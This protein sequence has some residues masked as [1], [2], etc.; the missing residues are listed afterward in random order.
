MLFLG[1]FRFMKKHLL[2]LL[3]LFLSLQ[4]FAQEPLPHYATEEEKSIFKDY[5][6]Q[7]SQQRDVAEP[8]PFEVRTMAEWEE[9]Q[10][11]VIT[12]TGFTGILTEI[13]RAAVEECTVL[14]VTNNPANTQ[15]QLEAANVPLDNIEF[16]QE[17]FNSIWI[18]DYGPWTVYGNDVD[19]LVL[20]DW[21][22]NRPRPLD[23]EIPLA[24]ANHLNLDIYEATSEPYNWVHTGGNHLRDGMGTAFS[25]DLV[26]DE[27]PGKTEE[28]IDNIAAEFLGVNRYIKLP[29]LPYDGISHLDMHM[30]IIDEET[31]IIGEYPEGVA[32]GPQIEEN[33]QYIK[34]NFQTPFGNEYN[35]VRI[36]MPPDQFDRY[37]DENGFYRTFTNSLFINKTIIVPIYEEQYDTTALR[38]Y[39]EN[40]P[41]YNVVGIDCNDIIPSLGALHCITKLVGANDPLWI[42]H[43]RIRDTYNTT[44]THL[45]KAIIKHKSGIENATL[46]YRQA[47][48]PAYTAVDMVLVDA[49]EDLWEASIPAQSAGTEIHYYIHATANSGKE[50]VR[51]LVAPEGYFKFEVLEVTTYPT[52]QFF[53]TST[54]ACPDSPI[55]FKDDSEGFVESWAWEFE[56]GTPA[57]STEQNPVVTF[58]E[59]GTYTVTLITTNSIGATSSTLEEY[60]TILDDGIIPDYEGFDDFSADIWTIENPTNDGAEWTIGDTQLCYDQAI[61]LDNFNTD[62][63]G[64]SDFINSRINLTNLGPVELSFDVAYAPYND[65]FFDGLRISV[66]DCDGVTTVVYDK[67][68]AELATAA[69]TTDAFVPS[70]EDWRHEVV[71]LSDFSG[72]VNIQIENRG[73]Y[74]N[75]L[76]LDNV[77]FASPVLANAAPNVAITAPADGTTYLNDLP[78]IT[79]DIDANDSDGNVQMVELFVNGESIGTTNE[80]PYSFGYTIPELG[81]YELVAIATDNLGEASTS[82][83]VTVI[84]D[85]ETNATEIFRELGIEVLPNPV[86]DILKLRLSAN[87]NNY[88][89]QLSNSLGQEIFKGRLE[90]NQQSLYEIDV[91][92]LAVGNYVL[93]IFDEAGKMHSMI[94]EVIR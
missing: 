31:I 14:I 37:P 57:T 41:G 87:A 55:E 82:S 44:D 50:Q 11:L 75:I 5:V 7:Q 58:A 93:S 25:S 89:Y 43:P 1:K 23:D 33:I 69:A 24:V 72:P 15:A 77:D 51:P 78:N 59:P 84:A 52:A 67:A 12:W 92:S 39:E 47:Q 32:D 4:L 16:I 9:I 46:Y 18:R 28:E 21:I 74:G 49:N 19:S 45:A 27:N 91:R 90:I 38:I 10:A 34:S 53:A 6:Q 61:S 56:G 35:I 8:P 65:N 30:R 80:S 20:V 94:I 66:T 85:E 81:E 71:D 29:K 62:T 70:C 73:G 40:L 42:A 26:F 64:T 3:V 83:T 36:Q 88:R 76:Y 60:I 54:V 86:S 17:G 79:I 68:G 48:E 22:Y 63:R 2:S 13:A